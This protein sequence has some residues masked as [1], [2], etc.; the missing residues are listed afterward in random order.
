MGFQNEK[1][2]DQI[3]LK[4]LTVLQE[5]ARVPLSRIGKKVGLSAPAVAERMRKLEEAGII[6]GYHARIAP[7][8]VGRSVSA[9]IKLTTDPQNYKAV[10]AL[11]VDM[12]EIIACH[13]ISGEGSFII[14]VQV[15]DLPALEA[16]VERLSPYG[17][18][19]TSIVLST[20]VDKTFMVPLP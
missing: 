11:A 4:I 14:Y 20:S 18:T 9:F 2:L 1:L 12:K 6:K 16:V 13:H 15:G 7:E 3:G 10:K 19:Q 8:A 17:Q 5:D